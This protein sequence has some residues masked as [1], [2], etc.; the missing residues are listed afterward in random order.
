MDQDRERGDGD[1]PIDPFDPF[2][3]KT[4][5]LKHFQNKIP[6]KIIIILLDILEFAEDSSFF[7][8]LTI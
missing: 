7:F 8:L 1:A 3:L 4:H 5:L 2:L 6:I